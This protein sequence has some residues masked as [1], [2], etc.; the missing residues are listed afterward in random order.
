MSQTPPAGRTP[1]TIIVGA[2]L[3]GLACARA[4]R[5]AGRPVLVLEAQD[6]VGGRVAT[7]AVTLDHPTLGGRYLVDR[8]FQIFLTAYPTARSLLDLDALDL[9]AFTPGAI[10]MTARGR[11]ELID[12]RARPLAAIASLLGVGVRPAVAPADVVRLARWARKLGATPLEAIWTQPEATALSRLRELGVSEGA[13]DRF[14]RPF[15]GGVFFDR[16]LATS[17][18]MLAFCV[19]MF[20]TGRAAVPAE[21]MGAIPRQ[22]ARPLAGDAIRTGSAVRSIRPTARGW[23]VAT[24]GHAIEG[25]ELVLATDGATACRLLERA[26]L[27]PPGPATAPAWRATATLAYACPSPPGGGRV[28]TLDGEAGGA[29][30]S[31]PVNH[32]AVM[33]AVAP[34]Y[35]PPGRGLVYANVVDP[36]ALALDD[37]A[38]DAAARDQLARWYGPPA[39][40]WALVR[41]VR[42]GHALPDQRP[43][44]LDPPARPQRA[45]MPDGRP[46]PLLCGDWLDNASIEGALASG[47]RAAAALT[48]AEGDRE[49]KH[50]GGA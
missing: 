16:E 35:A 2:G 10:V 46:G 31:N 18:R 28:L 14:L 1:P 3:A 32:L 11:R 8:G 6:R 40:A 17:S 19:R 39:R 9:R 48:A 24:D 22:L 21:G 45:A 38:L 44:H 5:D 34:G 25:G 4:L 47:L 49:R 50:A 30:P 42:I 23:S 37:G 41:L 36:G 13:I 33:S 7:D 27:A 29:G 43:P 15:F 20:A 12:P 26:G